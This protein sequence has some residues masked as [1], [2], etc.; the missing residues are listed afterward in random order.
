MD[1]IAGWEGT[2]AIVVCEE[3]Q[4]LVKKGEAKLQALANFKGEL[5]THWSLTPAILW[6][7]GLLG[8]EGGLALR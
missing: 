1:N 8:L 6:A 3:A 2:T 7:I 4:C 5:P